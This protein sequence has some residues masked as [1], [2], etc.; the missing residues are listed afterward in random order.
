MERKEAGRLF[1]L[2]THPVL[3]EKHWLVGQVQTAMVWL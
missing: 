3:S 1:Y 2:G